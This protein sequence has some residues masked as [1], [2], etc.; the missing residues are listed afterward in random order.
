M[1]KRG[2]DT[3]KRRYDAFISYCHGGKD[4]KL[5]ER[6]QVLLESYRLPKSEKRLR[7]FRDNTELIGRQRFGRRAS[8]GA[9]TVPLFDFRLFGENQGLPMVHGGDPAV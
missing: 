7:V 4:S 2:E 3:G 8:G 6:L 1:G 9:G 5:A